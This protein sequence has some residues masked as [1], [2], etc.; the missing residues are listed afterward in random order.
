M[1][2]L[3]GYKTY[4]GI[5]FATVGPILSLFNINIGD[6]TGIESAVVTLVGGAIALYGYLVTKRGA[7]KA[8]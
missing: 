6:L 8:M 5:F 2:F 7:P 1:K 4:I 3:D